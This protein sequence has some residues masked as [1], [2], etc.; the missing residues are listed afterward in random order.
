[1]Q[2]T[3]FAPG[4]VV[5]EHR[6]VRRLGAGGMGAVDLAEHVAT[7]AQRALKS[8]PAA[9]DPELLVRFQREAEA[10]ARL[11]GHPNVVRI[12]T[13]GVAHGR[14]YLVMELH[15]GGDLEA[16]LQAG[17]WP[18][19][20]VAKL[21]VALARGLSHAHAHGIIHR[22]LKPSNVLFAEDGRP[23]LVDFGLARSGD[24]QALTRSGQLLGT[25]L[26][27]APEQ[28][29][30]RSQ[31]IGP[32]TDVYGLAAVLYRA[33]TGRPPAVGEN[34]I[35]VLNKVLHVA[36][37]A[38][39][40]LVAGV[41]RALDEALL[42]GLA[43]EPGAR[44]PSVLALGRALSAVER[45]R[46]G[47]RGGGRAALGLAGLAGFAGLAGL[48]VFRRRVGPEE[49][50]A[51]APAP[52]STPVVVIPAPVTEAPRPAEPP[53]QREPRD[54]SADLP[55]RVEAIGP[56]RDPPWHDP[57]SEALGT[58]GVAQ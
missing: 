22:D 15:G 24:F 8:I 1:M 58:L 11:D 54:P 13:V 33:L 4:S 36:P 17:P 52:S 32:A 57:L 34:L 14:M 9:A 23:I 21:G 55:A 28:T 51:V 16:R 5:G 53:A 56:P 7:G 30:G 20:Q 29:D 44:F 35:E 31:L 37:P 6:I 18:A 50:A 45:G 47:A 42:R 49:L 46:R 41:P 2:H 27:M 39:S 48:A 10:L 3:G 26:Y 19:A 12:H 38:P 25:P 40:S 43:K